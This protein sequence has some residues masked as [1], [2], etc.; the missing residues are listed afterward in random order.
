MAYLQFAAAALAFIAAIFWLLSSR[1]K[2]PDEITVGYGG[3][4]GTAQDL[5]NALIKQSKLSRY[6]A[7]SAGAASICE[8]VFL[9]YF[10]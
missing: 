6:A 9:T 3:V 1:V 7:L 8:A 5:G 10:R 2:V 4:G